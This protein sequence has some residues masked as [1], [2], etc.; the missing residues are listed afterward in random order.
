[1]NLPP[2]L[3]VGA[4]LCLP[5]L[6]AVWIVFPELGIFLAQLDG[7]AAV[8]ILCLCMSDE[9][10]EREHWALRCLGS[11]LNVLGFAGALVMIAVAITGL[12]SLVGDSF[13]PG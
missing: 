6:I 8:S 3:L 11:G 2:T 4:A 13:W 1:M 12:M 10:E 5:V 7:A 9:L